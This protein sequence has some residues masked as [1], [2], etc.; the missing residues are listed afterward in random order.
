MKVVKEL[1]PVVKMVMVFVALAAL[2]SMLG[3]CATGQSHRT[4]V[5]EPGGHRTVYEAK[6]TGLWF[7]SGRA[8][9]LVVTADP[10]EIND[11]K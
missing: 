7:T 5:I 10:L 4:T 11:K 6:Q 3:G 8:D 1:Y 9:P 2:L